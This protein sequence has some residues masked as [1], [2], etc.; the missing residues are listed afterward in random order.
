MLKISYAGGL[1]ISPA[2]LSQFS[3]KMCTACKNCKKKSIKNP[4]F[5]CSRSFKIIDVDKS[6]K[7]V[8][9]A[10]CDKQHV[11]THL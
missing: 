8:N 7:P 9:S 6:E 1:G 5:V 10:C 2:I 11:W 3:L 4:Y